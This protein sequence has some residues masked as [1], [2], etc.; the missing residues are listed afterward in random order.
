[1]SAVETKALLLVEPPAK[2]P[3]LSLVALLLKLFPAL[4]EKVQILDKLKNRKIGFLI[5]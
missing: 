4:K 5:E 3:L 2:N 1:M